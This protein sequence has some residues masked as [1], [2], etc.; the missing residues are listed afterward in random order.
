MMKLS[1]IRAA[2]GGEMLGDASFEGIEI[3]SRTVKPGCLFVCL[4]GERADGHDY[5]V[6]AQEA[7][8][9]CLLC[10]RK[11]ESDLPCLIVPDAVKAL[12][13]F[14]SAYRDTLD[15]TLTAVTGSVGK[16]ST[17]ECIAAALSKCFK[18]YKTPGNMNSE[19]GLPRTILGI[20][21]SDRFAVTEMGMCNLGEIRVLTKIAK[22]NVAVITNIGF[23]HLEN[24]RTR[25]NILKAKLEILE[26]LAENG[27]LVYN[28]DDPYLCSAKETISRYRHVSYGKGDGCDLRAQNIRT[29][30]GTTTFDA[31]TPAGTVTVRMPCEGEH[32]VYNALAAVAVGL[33]MKMSLED[34]ASGLCDFTAV[35][36]RQQIF[37]RDGFHV[38]EDCYNAAPESMNAALNLLKWKQGRKVVVLG[39]ML[40]LGPLSDEMHRKVGALASF[41]DEAV[42]FG[43]HASCFAEGAIGA[44]MKKEKIRL[45]DSSLSAGK[46]LKKIAGQGDWILVK[47]SR[48]MHGENALEVF[49]GK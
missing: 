3:D 12:Q 38:I 23:C 17:K 15:V 28:G 34:I 49:F 43:P 26:G 21:P 35:P 37:D 2:A 36:M 46:M 16:T 9:A 7:G 41:A 45:A 31:V 1:E 47:S 40:E 5:A 33:E 29:E 39:D 22:P 13:D 10:E 18:T 27:L 48:G 44:G 30:N 6:R 8:A 25:E 19:T 20:T 4:K 42:F 14:A 11:T 32:H 24:L